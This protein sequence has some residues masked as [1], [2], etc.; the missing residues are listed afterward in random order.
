MAA[1]SDA[2]PIREVQ[3]ESGSVPSTELLESATPWIARGYLNDWPV[4]Q[5][6]KQSDGT[7]LAYLLEPTYRNLPRRVHSLEPAEPAAF[8]QWCQKRK[9][10][11]GRRRRPDGL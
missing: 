11:I 5:K 8:L 3:L 6:A 4:V 10:K 7:A 1:C 9:K 2:R